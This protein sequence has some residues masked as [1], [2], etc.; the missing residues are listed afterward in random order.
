MKLLGKIFLCLRVAVLAGLYDQAN[1][2]TARGAQQT[3]SRTGHTVE[4]IEVP[5]SHNP[6]AWR[7]HLSDVLVGLF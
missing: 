7:N 6:T 1:I 4:L 2:A 5:E 3:L